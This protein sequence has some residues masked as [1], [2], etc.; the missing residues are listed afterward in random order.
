MYDVIIFDIDETLFDF[1]ETEILALKRTVEDLELIYNKDYHY[2]LY[3][4]INSSLWKDLEKGLTTGD[5]LK[6]QRFELFAQALEIEINID[7]VSD[8][9]LSYLAHGA[10]LFDDSIPLLD[11]LKNKYVLSI[12]TNGLKYVQNIKI[13]K[14]NIGHYFKD[15]VISEEVNVSKPN[16]EI[17][18]IALS[19]L[20]Q[21]DKSRVLMIGDSLSS[22]IKGGNDFG[23]DTCWYNPNNK[24]NTTSIKPTYA[25]SSL[26][27]LFSIL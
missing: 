18:K 14:S 11:Y 27:D 4:E 8:N 25:I 17:F 26:K 19:N 7:Q 16:T 13:S 1:N 22:D 2:K 21:V 15:I 5:K 23:I 24:I 6:S 10:F 12:I 20:N 9:F 3:K